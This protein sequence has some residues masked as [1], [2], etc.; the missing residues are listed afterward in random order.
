MT[1]TRKSLS[2]EWLSKYSIVMNGRVRPDDDADHDGLGFMDEQSAGTNPYDSDT[3][4][5]GASDRE[6][7][8]HGTDPLGSGDLDTDYDGMP[9]PWEM[10]N[11][12]DPKKADAD[13]DA[14][15]D[16][17]PNI[18]EYAYG[19]NPRNID[20]D[21]DGFGD[22]QEIG[23]GYDPDASGDSKPSI[24]V[25]VERIG[26]AAPMIWAGSED[27]PSMLRDL[28]R[29]V[30]RY[31]GSGI[32]GQ[33]GNVIISGHSSNYVWAKGDYNSVFRRLGEL[34]PGDSIV[35]RMRQANG[36]TF[37]Y[38]YKMIEKRVTTPDDPWIFEAGERDEV[39]LSTCWPLGTAFKRLI[40]RGELAGDAPATS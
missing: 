12:T 24:T 21:G 28:E 39:T 7:F 38:A 26:V 36:K 13:V 19:T 6:E 25:L 9:N 3:D 15:G 10:A 34:A 22:A 17:L 23:N 29:G 20:T 16:G 33:S 30:I 40:V 1:V 37:D 14:D 11:G 2:S 5:D 18:G 4:D 31:P 32:P 35:L 27:E 8:D